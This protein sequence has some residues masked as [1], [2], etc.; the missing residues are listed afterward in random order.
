[1]L[2]SIELASLALEFVRDNPEGEVIALVRDQSGVC[3][4][5]GLFLKVCQMDFRPGRR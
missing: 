1:M 4:D 5:R 2:S 3:F